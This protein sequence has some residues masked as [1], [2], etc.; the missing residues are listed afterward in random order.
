MLS[1]ELFKNYDPYLEDESDDKIPRPGNAQELWSMLVL[2]SIVIMPTTID[3]I[4]GFLPCY[5]FERV[6]FVIT[7][8]GAKITKSY[9]EYI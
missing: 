5:K 9:F 7:L 6:M 8:E 3:L 4:F 2:E 1:E